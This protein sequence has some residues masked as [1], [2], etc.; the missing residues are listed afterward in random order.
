MSL[1]LKCDN[2]S[3]SYSNCLSATPPQWCVHDHAV[4]ARTRS[5]RNAKQHTRG[6]RPKD[7]A[8]D[9]TLTGRMKKHRQHLARS[10]RQ[11]FKK[12]VN[13][14]AKNAPTNASPK[15]RSSKAPTIGLLDTTFNAVR[16]LL[17]SLQCVRVSFP[18]STASLTSKVVWVAIFVVFCRESDGWHRLG[19]LKYVPCN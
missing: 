10:A 9:R 11:T 8:R 1:H 18:S 7:N 16:R 13:A 4:P 19:S 12:E 14:S 17:I 3:G 5:G 2:G 15:A 6:H